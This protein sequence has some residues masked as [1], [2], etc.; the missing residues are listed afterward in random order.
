MFTHQELVTPLQLQQNGICKA[1]S[2]TKR[3]PEF[4]AVLTCPSC[5][6][7]A[8]CYPYAPSLLSCFMPNKHCCQEAAS[9]LI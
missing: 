5:V 9:E 6:Y 4:C 2:A 1:A 8:V 7:P 3:K